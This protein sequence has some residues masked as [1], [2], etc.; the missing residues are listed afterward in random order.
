M[1]D[2]KK[3]PRT[4]AVP[5]FLLTVVASILLLV[6]A[7]ITVRAAWHMYGK[8]ATA[9]AAA[10][11]A[12]TELSHME[13][14]KAS[15][16]EAIESLSSSRGVEESLREKFGVAKPGEGEIRIVRDQDGEDTLPLNDDANIFMRI[17]NALFVW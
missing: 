3:N 4:H 5:K 2:Y 16:S 15:V 9:S 12:K 1:L 10:E 13:E 14:Q 17:F 6:V 7:V 8:F 11:A